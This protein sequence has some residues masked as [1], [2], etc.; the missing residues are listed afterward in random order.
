MTM[1]MA[2]KPHSHV[3][4]YARSARSTCQSCHQPIANRELRLLEAFITD[5]GSWGRAH[6]NAR[7]YTRTYDDDGRRYE[8][9]PDVVA[10]FH[11]LACAAKHQPYKLRSALASTTIEIPDR[12]TL[13][14]AI[15]R[16]LSVVDVAEAN[17]ETRDAYQQ[18][19]DDVREARDDE[20]L[21]VFGDWLQGTGD[22]RGELVATHRVLET[23]TGDERTQ[24]V[25]T[26]ERL[27]AAHRKQF[28]PDRLDGKLV[29]RRGFVQ[30]L[31]ITAPAGLDP[32]TL[33]RALAHPSFR[34]VREFAVRVEPAYFSTSLV[35]AANLPKP[36]P[37]TLRVIELGGEHLGDIGELIADSLPQLER[38]VLAGP[39]DLE[40]LRHPTL[41]ELE[42]VCHDASRVEP[43]TPRA[44][45][46][47]LTRRIVGLDRKRL[48]G[49]RHLVLRVARGLDAAVD[50]VA[51]T[52]LLPDL[53][54][55]TLHGDLSATGVTSL[56]AK[57]KLHLETLDVRGCT[58][59]GPQ[60]LDRLAKLADTVVRQEVVT[61]PAEPPP[62]KI[63]EWLVRHTRKPE[64]GIGRVVSEGDNG[65]E[66]E[67]EHGGTKQVRNV[68]L[69]EEIE[70]PS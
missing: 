32:V 56:L 38:L 17:P 14:E 9:T 21:L 22:P 48:P 3:I 70:R 45:P 61:P 12:A 35:V 30:R 39:A 46:Q 62:A 4:E 33:G 34:V 18:F 28:L 24:L 8:A 29:W 26:E 58:R 47:P 66:V 20:G 64:W 49:L 40:R 31:E 16:G 43:S 54:Q 15:E 6:K 7:T 51:E 67:F 57:Q 65:L 11:H 42:L 68:E 50:A 37:A 52:T 1:A 41:G 55:L 53:H 19:I 60:D 36:L 2:D 63:T 44:E 25:K 69:L 23:A 13:E 59:L 10:R 27:I 5:E